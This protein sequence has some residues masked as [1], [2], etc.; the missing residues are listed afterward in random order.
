MK[1]V[2]I[3]LIEF[4]QLYISP[5]KKVNCCKF[6]PCCSSYAKES[7]ETFGL[8]KGLALSVFRLIRCSPISRGGYDPVKKPKNMKKSKESLGEN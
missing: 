1:R 2:L 3:K 5:R 8:F 7:I 6:Y 4:Y